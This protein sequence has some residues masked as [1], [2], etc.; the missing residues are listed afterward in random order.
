MVL[1]LIADQAIGE[2]DRRDADGLGFDA[3]ADV[4]AAAAT[5]T[6]GP[7]TIGVFGEWGTGKTSLMR[8]VERRLDEDPG[9]VTVWFNAW[10]YEQEEHPIVPLVGTIVQALE[11][12]KGLNQQ[13]GQAGRRL[14]RSLRAIAYGF[15]AKSKVSVPGF[16]EFEASFVAK[17]MIE[18]DNRLTPDPL[19][20]RSLYF[21]A[22]TSLDEVKLRENVRVVVLIDDLDRCFPDQAIRL[23]ESIKL[24]L[25]QPGFI[26]VLGVARK[27][28]E[29]YLQHR[30]TKDYG[31]PDFKGELYLDKIVQLPFHI[32]P[33]KH[34]MAE[35]CRTL[36][37]DQ[38]PALVTE[39]QPVLPVAAEALGGNPRAV[40]R[41][42]NN[43]LVDHAISSRLTDP[44]ARGA[45]PIRFFAVSRCLE[46]RWPDVFA[47]LTEQDGL[48][49]D[50]ATWTAGGY[51]AKAGGTGPEAL[52]A[53]KL[54]SDP[55]LRRLLTQGPGRDWLTEPVLRQASVSFL[56]TRDRLSR[57]DTSEVE[58]RYDAFVSFA[59]EDRPAVIRLVGAL[60]EAG[61]RVF[62]DDHVP[63]GS[64]WEEALDSGLGR[65]DA[66]LYCVGRTSAASEGQLR[67]YGTVATRD[68]LII[69]VLLP[70]A[71][72]ESMPPLLRSR[73]WLDLRYGITEDGVQQLVS[74]LRRRSRRA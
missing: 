19:L 24:V 32:P 12:H 59:N 15:S 16:A 58:V 74:A 38:P 45:I 42:L 27:V 46:H 52:V 61:V 18:R 10:R 41:F 29:G 48:A 68:L 53:G 1:R 65:A 71:D 23:L 31:I 35:F 51:D 22:F 44:G 3:Y 25:A 26:F 5:D 13:F 14:V 69:P 20:D 30:Y 33:A 6:R 40:I 73:Q 72:P 21:G 63:L 62:F 47:A 60:S 67:E 56:I 11:K 70:G 8:L 7:F 17:D 50:V 28:V 54:I 2:A 9:V 43:I 49:E 55:E 39:L 64:R 37:A 66:L 4:L 34:R 36:L 57:L